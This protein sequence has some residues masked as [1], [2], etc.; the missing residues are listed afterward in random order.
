MRAL[1]EFASAGHLDLA[2]CNAAWGDWTVHTDAA[3]AEGLVIDGRYTSD[4]GVYVQDRTVRGDG[5]HRSL[6]EVVADNAGAPWLA[7]CY[8]TS[9]QHGACSDFTVDAGGHCTHG[10]YLGKYSR[11]KIEHMEASGALDVGIYLKECQT[12]MLV[13]SLYAWASLRGI[14]AEGCNALQGAAWRAVGCLGDGVSILGAYAGPAPWPFQGNMA[15]SG[16][17]AEN[18]GGDGIV[19]R[20]HAWPVR[21]DGVYTEAIFGSALVVDNATVYLGGGTLRSSG[22]VVHVRNGGRLMVGGP[23][24]VVGA[25]ADPVVIVESGCTFE[26]AGYLY[27]VSQSVHYEIAS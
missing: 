16:V 9:G 4:R 7:A 15:I 24:G 17:H 14:V 13:H 19:V 1:S 22:P 26:G 5:W 11:S 3:L 2:A 23:V 21:V 20:D 10:V 18:C 27:G 25:G 12:S 8:A 6:V